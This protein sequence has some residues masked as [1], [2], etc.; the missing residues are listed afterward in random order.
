MK[1]RAGIGVTKLRDREEMDSDMG[2]NLGGVLLQ[3]EKECLRMDWNVEECY[4]N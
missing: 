3:K 2:D 4:R 1:L